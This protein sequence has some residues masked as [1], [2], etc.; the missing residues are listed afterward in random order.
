MKLTIA[1]VLE[2]TKGKLMYGSGGEM[3]TGVSTDSRSAQK[4]DLFVAL[5]GPKHDGHEF[6][7]EVF[8]KGTVGAVVDK[9]VRS[10]LVGDRC[11]IKVKNTLA[12]LGDLA[13]W[14]RRRFPVR[15][16]A[17]TGSNGKTTTKDMIAALLSSKYRILKTEGNFNNLIGLPLT[18]F[19]L[20]ESVE[21]AVL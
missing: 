6:L 1:E 16:V 18:V 2:A 19:R 15:V 12:A 8:R 10:R 20:D 17:I 7:R 4:G 14:W 13:Q 3:M 11:I 21:V 5:H 9:P